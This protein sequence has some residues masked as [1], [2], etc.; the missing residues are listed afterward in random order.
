MNCLILT[1][2]FINPT[3]LYKFDVIEN[4]IQISEVLLDFEEIFKKFFEKLTL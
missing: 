2:V 1:H 4:K 3:E